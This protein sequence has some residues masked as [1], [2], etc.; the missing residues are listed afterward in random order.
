MAAKDG[1]AADKL[2]ACVAGNPA[3]DSELSKSIEEGILLEV[4]ST[5][6]FFVNG[7]RVEGGFPGPFWDHMIEGLMKKP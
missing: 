3:I 5:P 4:H 7:H 1:V 2:A 6:T